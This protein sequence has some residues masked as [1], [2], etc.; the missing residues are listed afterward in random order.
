MNIVNIESVL[1]NRVIH[2]LRQAAIDNDI[3]MRHKLAAAVVYK[4]S[5]VALGLNSYKTHP[6][7]S[8][9]GKNDQS[10]FLHAEV[11]AIK[12]ALRV[13]SPDDLSRCDLYVYRVKKPAQYRT[14]WI[15]GLARPCQGCMRAIESFNLRGVYYSL[16]QVDH[17]E[18]LSRSHL[19]EGSEPRAGHR[20]QA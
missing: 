3:S 18:H 15:T 6:L 1:H 4:R 10:V 11:D 12:N 13:I 2:T 8:R 20:A 16:D 5:V 14:N 17:L 19:R 9:Y 7:M